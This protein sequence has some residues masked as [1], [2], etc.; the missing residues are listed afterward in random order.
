MKIVNERKRAISPAV[1]EY[2]AYRQRANIPAAGSIDGARDRFACTP[3]SQPVLIRATTTELRYT[4][5]CVRILGAFDT[6]SISR[7]HFAFFKYAYTISTVVKFSSPFFLRCR[8]IFRRFPFGKR[9]DTEIRTNDATRATAT[10]LRSRRL[11]AHVDELD[12]G[13]RS[14]RIYRRYVPRP[15]L[16]YKRTTEMVFLFFKTKS[17]TNIR[18]ILRV[19]H[20]GYDSEHTSVS[21]SFERSPQNESITEFRSEKFDGNIRG[22][23]VV[24]GKRVRR[25]YSFRVYRV[26]RKP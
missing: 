12:T 6:R 15:R 13:C 16:T 21:R 9:R 5:Y 1:A 8:P 3:P 26:A 19:A 4:D 22:G 24:K 23:Y 17:Y 10:R 18:S 2:D 11:G 25:Y 14:K 20:R 7:S